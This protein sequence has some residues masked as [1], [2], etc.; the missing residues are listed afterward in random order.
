MVPVARRWR[1]VRA[2]NVAIPASVRRFNQRAR[3]HRLRSARPWIIAVLVL[4]IAGIGAWVIF[5]TSAL[6]VERIQVKGSGFVGDQAVRAAAQ[7]DMGTPLASIDLD[8]IAR[9][10]ERLPGV[11]VAHVHRDWPSTLIIDV[12][13]RTAVAAVPI[14]KTYVLL[15]ASGVAFRR[16]SA[17]PTITLITLRSPGRDDPAT[18]AALS[19]L[20]SLPADIRDEL[21]SMTAATP[22]D[23]TLILQ[24]HRRVIWGDASDNA[25]KGRVATSLLRRPGT[26]IDVSA[27]NVVTVR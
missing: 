2:P 7:V 6:G 1:L 10:V 3:A 23:V 17:T 25:A 4:V 27:P 22:A 16:V 15:D 11:R 21:V 24:G 14:G 9:K 26:V 19:V 20:R 12:T 18:Q 8:A 13:R 5:G